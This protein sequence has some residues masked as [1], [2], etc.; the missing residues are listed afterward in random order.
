[1]GNHDYKALFFDLS[2]HMNRE[3]T[4]KA[5]GNGLCETI[6]PYT[7]GTVCYLVE[8]LSMPS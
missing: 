7:A 1:M 6:L 5:S 2:I 4:W 8:N 3:C